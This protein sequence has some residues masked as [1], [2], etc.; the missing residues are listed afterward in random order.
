[1]EVD[2]TS[3]IVENHGSDTKCYFEPQKCLS[4]FPAWSQRDQST[5]GGLLF[6]DEDTAAATASAAAFSSLVGI[7]LRLGFGIG[8][9]TASRE[10]FQ[11]LN[12]IP[13]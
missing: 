11:I 10:L 5:A 12:E 8:F 4:K 6:V 2:G 3:K 9:G 13:K 1:M 7:S